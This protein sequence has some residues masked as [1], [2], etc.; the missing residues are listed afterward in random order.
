MHPALRAREHVRPD[1]TSNQ[2]RNVSGDGNGCVMRTRMAMSV[3]ASVENK[4]SAGVEPGSSQAWVDKV[5]TKM[6]QVVERGG[7]V[8]WG[9]MG[10]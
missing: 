2:E 1:K 8:G 5:Q 10:G 3:T 4:V 9:G 6:S 7:G